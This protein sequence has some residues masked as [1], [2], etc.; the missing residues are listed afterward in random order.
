MENVSKHKSLKHTKFKNL[1]QKRDAVI[2]DPSVKGGEKF[3]LVNE[4]REKTKLLREAEE[5]VETLKRRETQIR[6]TCEAWKKEVI[7]GK[8]T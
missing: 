1:Y 4:I 2:L 3:K 6:E 8:I 5:K 7:V